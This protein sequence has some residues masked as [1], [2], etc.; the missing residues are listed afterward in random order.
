MSA[1]QL[2]YKIFSDQNF[3]YDYELY[4]I[5]GLMYHKSYQIIKDFVNRYP[6]SIR[7]G[8]TFKKLL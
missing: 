6:K 4:R 3:T 8:N 2:S 1:S 5:Q 7:L